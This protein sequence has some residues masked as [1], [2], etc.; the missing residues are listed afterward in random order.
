MMFPTI[1]RASNFYFF[2]DPN[3]KEV[4]TKIFGQKVNWPAK[5]W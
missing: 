3:T 5:V 4:G 2:I 1:N